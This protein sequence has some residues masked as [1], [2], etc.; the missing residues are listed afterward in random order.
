[1]QRPFTHLTLRVVLRALCVSRHQYLGDHLARFFQKFGLETS[2]AVGLEGAIAVA[3][4]VEPQIVLCDY[5]LLAT[6][7]LDVWE[8]DAL[9]S[10]TPVVAVSMT[11][12]PE[13]THVLDVN[14]IGGFL[15]LPTLRREDALVVLGAAAAP[16]YARYPYADALEWRRPAALDTRPD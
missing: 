16:R 3:R 15:Y 1:M 10:R 2:Y 7:P 5:D 9:L 4:Q 6:L 12:R 13:E 11:R 14:G 8:R